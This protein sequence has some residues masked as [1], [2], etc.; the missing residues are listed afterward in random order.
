VKEEKRTI[1][2]AIKMEDEEM[3]SSPAVLI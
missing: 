2:K 1:Q 3:T